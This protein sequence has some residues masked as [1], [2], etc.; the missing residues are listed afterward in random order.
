MIQLKQEVMVSNGNGEKADGTFLEA[1][2]EISSDVDG[3][4]KE[5]ESV[6]SK[7]LL[8]QID[9]GP[10]SRKNIEFLVTR[11]RSYAK[12]KTSGKTIEDNAI[13]DINAKKYFRN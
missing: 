11:V 1:L 5:L 8:R 4:I 13:Q 9:Q 2:D 3:A 10:R 6:H 12:G 7:H